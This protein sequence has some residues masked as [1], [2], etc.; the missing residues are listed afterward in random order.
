MSVANGCRSNCVPSATRTRC[1]NKVHDIQVFGTS[2][3][4]APLYLYPRFSHESSE[5]AREPIKDPPYTVREQQLSQSIYFTHYELRFCRIDP[6]QNF[7]PIKPT[8]FQP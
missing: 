1:Q 4:Y 2:F 5:T 8:R 3:C 7:Q 6:K